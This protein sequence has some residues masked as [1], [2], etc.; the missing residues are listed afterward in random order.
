MQV[1]LGGAELGLALT[2]YV[3]SVGYRRHEDGGAI[4]K[5]AV[6]GVG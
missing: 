3:F 6:G 1:S 4:G 5:G 2:G